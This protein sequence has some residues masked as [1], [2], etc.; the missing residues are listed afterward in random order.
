MNALGHFLR[1]VGLALV[2]LTNEAPPA[3]QATTELDH[4]MRKALEQFA[5]ER[6]AEELRAAGKVAHRIDSR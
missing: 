4:E 3:E 2:E 5:E 6:E 1:R